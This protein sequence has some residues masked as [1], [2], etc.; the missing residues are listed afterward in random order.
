MRF[1][2][3]SENFLDVPIRVPIFVKLE[4][5]FKYDETPDTFGVK[6]L[7]FSDPIRGPIPFLI[8]EV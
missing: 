2:S 7:I 8:A 4:Q 6:F 3:Y 1:D 5:L